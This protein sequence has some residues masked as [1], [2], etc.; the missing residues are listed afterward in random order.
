ML[1]DAFIDEQIRAVDLAELPVFFKYATFQAPDGSRH[2]ISGKALTD[3]MDNHARYAQARNV[4]VFVNLTLL[5]AVWLAEFEAL[6]WRAFR[7][8]TAE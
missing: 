5:K 1:S 4:R 7:G 3:L 8:L 6:K 2:T